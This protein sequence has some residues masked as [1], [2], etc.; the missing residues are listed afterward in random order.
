[1]HFLTKGTYKRLKEKKAIK[2][3]TSNI[4][5]FIMFIMLIKK[6]HS[7]T[8]RASLRDFSRDSIVFMVW[9]MIPKPSWR[10][11]KY[12]SQWFST[13]YKHAWRNVLPIEKINSI[14]CKR[15]YRPIVT[16][17]WYMKYCLSSLTVKLRQHYRHDWTKETTITYHDNI[18]R[19]LRFL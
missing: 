8:P 19:A 1:M 13:S 17:R 5:Q 14:N 16:S 4:R 11:H 6:K 7:P 3:L 18:P 12:G 2:F 10:Q 9:S 15:Y